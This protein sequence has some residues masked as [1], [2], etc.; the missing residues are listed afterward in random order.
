MREALIK[1]YDGMEI[2]EEDIEILD[3]LAA[4]T[5]IEYRLMEDG[6]VYAEASRVAKGLRSLAE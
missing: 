4:A 1:Y 3:K 6:R 2:Q 5:Y